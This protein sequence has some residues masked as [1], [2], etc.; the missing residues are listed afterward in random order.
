MRHHARLWQGAQLSGSSLQQILVALLSLNHVA[1]G[2]THCS[3]PVKPPDVTFSH[4]HQPHRHARWHEASCLQAIQHLSSATPQQ[5][6][7]SSC[8]C[9]SHHCSRSRCGRRWAMQQRCAC[10][11]A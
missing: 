4:Q 11:V 7:T 5:L 3:T 9:S 2:A 10:L 6:L 8:C 1:C